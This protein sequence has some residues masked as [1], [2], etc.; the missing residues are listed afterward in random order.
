MP[1][2]HSVDYKISA[3]KHYLHKTNN[4]TKT[5]REFSCSRV[6]LM[7]WVKRYKKYKTI[8]RNNRNPISYKITKSQ[9]RYALDLLKKNEQI[10]MKELVKQTKKKY[11]SFSI[12]SQHLGQVLRD[13]N[14]TRKRTRHQHFPKTRYGKTLDKQKELDKFYKE[15]DKYPLNKIISLDETSIRPAMIPE[16]S[17]C[18][19]GKRCVYKTDDSYI[20]RSF[21]L[22]MAIN[23]NKYLGYTLYE[24]GGMTKERLKEFIQKFINGKYKNNL[25][26][27]DNA[28][29]H[30]N[31]LIKDTITNG[32]NK[33]LYSVPYTP[34]TNG[35]IEASFNQVKHYLKLNKKVLKFNELK[36]EVKKA[37]ENIKPQNY[38]NYFEYF[39][40]KKDNRKYTRKTSTR[41]RKYKNY[42]TN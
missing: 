27:L 23:D 28:G 21:T 20:Y 1:K 4:Y 14:R 29:S 6:T 3:I 31:Q 15:V 13:G 10:T 9:R 5:C 40:K 37:I 22:L 8:E 17:R 39:Y 16:Y 7:R 26:I 36:N 32:G 30:N 2:H 38:K 42:K 18:Y 19:I 24:K 25:I 34:R 41:K 33:Y 11:P 35:T 12:T